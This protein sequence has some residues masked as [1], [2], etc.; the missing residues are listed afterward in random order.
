MNEKEY[1]MPD[2]YNEK[3]AR[4]V[5]F[6]E[7]RDRVLA[8]LKDMTPEQRRAVQ[9]PLKTLNESIETLEKHLAVLYEAHQKEHRAEEKKN[10]SGNEL[11]RKMQIMY[12]FVKQRMPEKLDKFTK[13]LDNLSPE[14]REEFFDGVA[15][16]ETQD[17]DE[18]L[19]EGK[20]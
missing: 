8:A 5:E 19:A 9:E 15:I 2:D 16:L 17:L 18:L 14:Q 7:T 6:I 11:M 10:K 13:N 4:L 20:P 3:A 1:P 12:I